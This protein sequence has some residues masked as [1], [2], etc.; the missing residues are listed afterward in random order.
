M[1]EGSGYLQ[2]ARQ[3]QL[4]ARQPLRLHLDNQ[5]KRQ[6]AYGAAH[7]GDDMLT[8]DLLPLEM[9]VGLG[10]H[11]SMPNLAYYSQPNGHLISLSFRALLCTPSLTS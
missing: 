2:A 1:V 11:V 7:W 6:H 4:F 10:T 9:A 8:S 3:L 5:T